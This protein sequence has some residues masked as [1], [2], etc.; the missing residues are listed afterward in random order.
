[1]DKGVC[2]IAGARGRPGGEGGETVLLM[3][4]IE[5]GGD[6]DETGL[7]CLGTSGDGKTLLASDDG[8]AGL[9]WL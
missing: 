1:M 5:T 7:G 8:G 3:D 6:G 4:G 9:G 2:F